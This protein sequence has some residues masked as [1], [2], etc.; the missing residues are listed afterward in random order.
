M[1]LPELLAP[2]GG[3]KQLK[4]A[5]RFGADA[6]YLGA[7]RYGMR[8]HAGNFDEEALARATAWCHA[9]GV[10]VYLTLN[11]FAYDEDIEPLVDLAKYAVRAC[12]VDALIM[13]D[14]G[15]I[16]AVMDALPEAEIHLSTQMST[17]NARAVRFWHDAGIKRVVLSREV[18]LER[19]KALRAAIPQICELEAF[20]HGAV[21]MSYSGRCTLSKYLTGRDANRGDCAQA[22]RW[23]YRLEEQK[24]PG[25]YFP[26]EETESGVHIFSAGDMNMLPYLD[27]LCGVPLDSL[28]IEGRMK[29]EYY[30]ATVVGA[31]RQALNAIARGEFDDETRARLSGELL[32]ISH[33]PYDTGFY[34]GAPEH[35]G[36]RDWFT[37]SRE[38]AAR[39]LSFSKGRAMIEVKNKILSGDSLEL[40]TPAGTFGF[41]LGDITRADGAVCSACP[42]PNSIVTIDLPH[43]CEE[44]DL[45]R[46]TC[47]NHQTG[48]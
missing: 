27:Q 11:I 38:L 35:P 46:G 21:C 48:E 32:K 29:N 42:Q 8:A 22:C 10:K 13:A 18:S 7:N 19:I 5:V 1:R 23:T 4:A 33:R 44:G 25:E 24:R 9:R 14:P 3:E 36:D 39:V 43:P 2:A 16:A 20:V 28:K 6:V 31:Y 17:M 37:Q 47:R 45:I 15:A 40:M 34:F 41:T 26:V 30:V 12:G